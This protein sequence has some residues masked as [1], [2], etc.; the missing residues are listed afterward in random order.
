MRHVKAALILAFMSFNATYASTD[1]EGPEDVEVLSDSYI[2]E[3]PDIEDNG[4]ASDIRIDYSQYPFL[5]PAENKIELNGADW[6]DFFIALNESENRAVN[7][8]HIGD[9]HI[10]ADMATGRTRKLLQERFGALGRGL[11]VPLKLAGTNEPL[12]YSIKSDGKFRSE[13]LIAC[14]WSGKM[15]FTGVSLMPETTEFSF[16]LSTR[17]PFERINVY[18]DG[19]ALN[20][21][22]IEYEGSPLVFVANEE[23][24]RLEIGLP[25]PCED[26]AVRFT[27]LGDVYIYGME[28]I[29]D[30]IG[31][32]YHSIGING[33]TYLNYNRVDG[34][35]AD[36]SMLSPDLIIVSLGT[37]EAFGRLNTNEFETQVD[38]LVTELQNNNPSASLLLV[39]PSE[40]QRRI[41]RGRRRSYIVN[42]KVA[43]VRNVI[44]DYG[45][46]K[47][48]AV[49]DWYNVAGGQ[50]ASAEWL[51]SRLLG[52]D[53]VHYTLS[54]YEL[55]GQMLYD[56][57]I[58]L[59]D[60]DAAE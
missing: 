49:Y 53:R 59:T 34:L 40:C 8:V 57:L 44:K 10:Q 51:S 13:K 48:I 52:R 14:L 58:S 35:G 21:K 12:D 31:I 36:I 39:T 1:T 15:G 28:L 43:Q 37:N 5:K 46:R 33:A 29:S 60:F 41:R 18:Y 16:N 27:T 24:G 50:G 30:M 4:D 32:A 2:R 9:S 7:I 26:I 23:S 56:A 54:G 42:D 11:V 47:G 3:N 25:F 20:V 17:E 6:T 38:R 22:S 19:N 55:A 45:R